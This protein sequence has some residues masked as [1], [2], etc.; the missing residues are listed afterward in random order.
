[1][2]TKFELILAI[3][4][5][6][7][8]ISPTSLRLTGGFQDQAI[9]RCQS[10]STATDPGCHGNKFWVKI[11]YNSACMRDIFEILAFS[12]VFR[13]ELLKDVS[14]II[15]RNLRNLAENWL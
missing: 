13:V 12:K 5:L 2:Q 10:N 14:Q 15:S 7:C 4:R 8:E 3:T 11:G 6:I 1:M 9:E